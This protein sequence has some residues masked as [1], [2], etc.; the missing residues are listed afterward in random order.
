M[1][2]LFI[3]VNNRLKKLFLKFKKKNILP[4]EAP[5]EY[6]ASFLTKNPVIIEA[7]AHIG[8]DTVEMSKFWPK[9]ME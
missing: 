2:R 3:K 1:R 6:I 5:K 8:L 4:G 7:G 9:T